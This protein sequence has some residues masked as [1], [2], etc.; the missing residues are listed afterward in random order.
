MQLAMFMPARELRV[1]DD[2]GYSS[3]LVPG[4]FLPGQHGTYAKMWSQK[5]SEARLTGDLVK[6]PHYDPDNP[7]TESE[8]DEAYDLEDKGHSL[9]GHLTRDFEMNWDKKRSLRQGIE[10]EGIQTP[11]SLAFA[12]DIASTE[13]RREEAIE[14]QRV[15]IDGHHRI[16]AAYDLN[17]DM[18]VPVIYEPRLQ[19]HSDPPNE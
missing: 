17:P 3:D 14:G 16:A 10:E 19:T 13:K 2:A 9:P 12:K 18:E 15:I 1:S 6:N 5:V 4:D 11:V 7:M 8:Y